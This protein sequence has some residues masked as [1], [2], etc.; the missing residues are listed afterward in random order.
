M[1]SRMQNGEGTEVGP[2]VFGSVTNKGATRVVNDVTDAADRVISV[3]NGLEYD[4]AILSQALN[5]A[6]SI[7]AYEIGKA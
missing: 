3:V 1:T 4:R 7:L 2:Q 5:A 6:D